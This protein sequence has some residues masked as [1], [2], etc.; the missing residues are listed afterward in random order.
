MG[1]RLRA[2]REH[3]EGEEY[4]LAN[5]GDTLTDAHLPDLI[6]DLQGQQKVASFLCVRPNYTFHLVELDE[7]HVVRRI[8]E[9]TRSDI[10][11]NG[12]YFVFRQ[13]V[14]E[15]IG[16]GEDLVEEPF[17][18]L[19]VRQAL[20]AHRYEGFWAPM[21]TLKDKQQLEAMLEGGNGPWRV[22][23]PDTIVEPSTT[24]P[25]E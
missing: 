14:F 20:I 18:R 23:E 5:Y 21:D 4:F 1:E 7:R 11:I 24:L 22:W 13:D 16:Q 25:G 10:W 19:I 15:H 12:G 2:V 17:R 8:Q 6:S 3:L 9:S